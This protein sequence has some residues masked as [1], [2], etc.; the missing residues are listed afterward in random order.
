MN[1]QDTLPQVELQ[2][3]G[4]YQLLRR[5]G[6][7][8][9]GDVWLCQ[10]PHLKR[11][12]AVK[13]LPPH[14]Q[15]DFA[16][17]QR[18]ERE[19]QAAA[20]LAHPHILQV[21]DYGKQAL[22]DGVV[23]PYIVMP[24]I[25][26]SSLSERM[27][28]YQRQRILMPPQDALTILRQAA[29]AI[30][31]AHQKQIVHRDIKPA[32]MLLRSND[33]LLLA[34]FGIARILSGSEPLTQKGYDFGT[35]EYMAPEQAQGQANITSDNYSLA[36]IAYQLFTDRLPF[37]GETAIA[38]IMQHLTDQPLAP[39][40]IAPWLPPACEPILLQGLAKD[41]A[42]RPVLACEF[43]E[44]LAQALDNKAYQPAEMR[45]LKDL[46][47]LNIQERTDQQPE[48]MSEAKPKS[49]LSRRSLLTGGSI[50]A[51]LLAGSGAIAWAYM[52]NISATPSL[53]PLPLVSA[54]PHPHGKTYPEL[55]LTGGHNQS[56]GSTYWSPDSR[57]LFSNGFD[58][59]IFRWDIPGLM[60]HPEKYPFYS[61]Q[62]LRSSN[63]DMQ[64]HISPDGQKIAIS[65]YRALE[66]NA[67]NQIAI[68]TPDLK[69]VSRLTI[70]N[71]TA[72]YFPLWFPNDYLMAGAVMQVPT[73]RQQNVYVIDTNQPQRQWVIKAHDGSDGDGINSLIPHLSPP[74]RLVAIVF[75]YD[76][77]IGTI[78]I[79]DQVT[80][81]TYT[82]I[83]LLPRPSS[84]TIGTN[85]I[86]DVSWSADGKALI[87]LLKLDD[88]YKLVSVDW[89]ASNP[90]LNEIPLPQM[91]RED[92]PLNIVCNPTS[93]QPSIA[94]V[95]HLGQVYLLD[96]PGGQSVKLEHNIVEP[97]GL[98]FSS[99]SWSPDGNWLASSYDDD[100]LSILV[101]KLEGR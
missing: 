92:Y 13:M 31:Y 20:R 51:A 83:N 30:D 90:Q 18:F 95:S 64:M 9:M 52:R 42:Q 33:W 79:T 23:I 96:V 55:Q 41:P 28:S 80:W 48:Q 86:N 45:T 59:Q 53:P 63:S 100:K 76:V 85:Y 94:L 73:D 74:N 69:I 40:E 11:Q 21:H 10:D 7:G 77:E 4:R 12:V 72:Y 15:H 56:P 50:V 35:P 65:N 91:E 70:E 71:A 2:K 24:Y 46:P 81:Q 93:V 68:T 99:L 43:V 14:N 22:P 60:Q 37:Q 97:N 101:W 26:G 25:E 3:L 27:A 44:Q 5:V 1:E 32:N 88:K 98:L 67:T 66:N 29:Q 6:R 8:G 87:A 89:Q 49:W 39:C 16:F 47:E 34:D 82:R 62:P 75:R 84:G 57:Y 38:T 58:A 78:N 54:H 61:G 36:V 19:A 17:V